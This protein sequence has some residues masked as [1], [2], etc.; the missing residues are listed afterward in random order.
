MLYQTNGTLVP[1]S[2]DSPGN[3]PN[4]K[5]VNPKKAPIIGV[6]SMYQP[7]AVLWQI[8]IFR[9]KRPPKTYSTRANVVLMLLQILIHHKYRQK[10]YFQ[11]NL[12]GWTAFI[13]QPVKGVHRG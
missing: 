1:Q 12:M 5:C 2:L 10:V 3:S 6:T 13:D 4:F 9:D 7:A 8:T 11:P